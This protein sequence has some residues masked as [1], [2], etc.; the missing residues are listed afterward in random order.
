MF[1]LCSLK[2]SNF[3]KTGFYL[4]ISAHSGKISPKWAG[5]SKT[6]SAKLGRYPRLKIKLISKM[7]IQDPTK[8]CVNIAT[9]YSLT[10]WTIVLNYWRKGA[11]TTI[12]HYLSRCTGSNRISE[13]SIANIVPTFHIKPGMY[14]GVK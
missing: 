3:R 2:S 14:H 8:V 7:F 13:G 12:M 11:I 1:L 10:Q 5:F 4:E 9:G 6:R